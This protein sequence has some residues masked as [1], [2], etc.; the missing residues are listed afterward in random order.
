MI[1]QWLPCQPHVTLLREPHVFVCALLDS[2]LK[3]RF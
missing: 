1:Q 2:L 3:P